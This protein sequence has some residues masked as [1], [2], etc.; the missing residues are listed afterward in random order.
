MVMMVMMMLVMVMFWR[1]L[2]HVRLNVVRFGWYTVVEGSVLV[3]VE[4]VGRG[5]R[6]SCLK[7]QVSVRLGLVLSAFLRFCS[8][9]AAR[10]KVLL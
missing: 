8:V 9:C 10:K 2:R 3:V 5:L 6:S 1:V 7:I 4:V